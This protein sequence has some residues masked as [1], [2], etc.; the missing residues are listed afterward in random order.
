VFVV[1]LRFSANKSAAPDHMAGHNAWIAKGFEEGAF[2]L[3]GS[4]VP[5]LGGVV[6][7]NGEDRDALERRIQAD[8]FVVADVVT[9]E[10]HE[11]APGRT[12]PELDFLTSK[13]AAHA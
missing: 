9:A 5:G 6:I 7:A 10:I 4:L 8:P 11:V 1:F 2:V 3:T 12:V 13:V